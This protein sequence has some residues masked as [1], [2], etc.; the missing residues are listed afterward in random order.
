M[1]H[2][3]EISMVTEVK[4]LETDKTRLKGY[5]DEAVNF[6]KIEAAHEDTTAIVVMTMYRDG[7]HAYVL[8]GDYVLTNMVGSFETVKFDIMAGSA[9]A[10]G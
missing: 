2:I 10:D 1:K 5:L 7:S 8:A 9:M 4:T 3:G 6:V